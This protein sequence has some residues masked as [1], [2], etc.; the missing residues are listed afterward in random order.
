MARRK[1]EVT[2][3]VRNR[4]HPFQVEIVVPGTGLGNAMH[5]MFR[6]SSRHDHATVGGA[7]VMRWCF[8]ERRLADAFVTEFGGKRV[9]MPV[10]EIWIKKDAPSAGELARRAKAMQFGLER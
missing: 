9:D 4:T 8:A 6:W 3:R 10:D 7:N 1:G 2:D 5:I